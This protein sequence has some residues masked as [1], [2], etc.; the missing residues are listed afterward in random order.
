MALEPGQFDNDISD[1]I[2]VS[3][4]LIEK[5]SNDDIYSTWKKKLIEEELKIDE[6][7]KAYNQAN[8]FKH[9]LC[10]C[11]L[12]KDSIGRLKACNII[13]LCNLLVISK[14]IK[15]LKMLLV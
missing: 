7:L 9:V 6:D 4:H 3:S 13:S 11:D 12:D 15:D 10:L 14:N 5:D 8:N 2:F 1:K